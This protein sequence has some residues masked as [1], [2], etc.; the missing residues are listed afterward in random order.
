MAASAEYPEHAAHRRLFS[1]LAIG[2]FTVPNRIVNSTHGTGLDDERELR[3]LQERARGGAGFLG[4]QASQGVRD[5]AVGTGPRRKDP[6]WDERALHP[7]SREGIAHFDDLVIPRLRRRAEI[8]HAEGARC[9]A[10]LYHP[11]AARHWRSVDPVVA[12]STVVDPYESLTP[13]ALRADEVLDLV[14]AFAH[15]IRRIAEAGMDAAELHGAH[16]YLINQFLSPYFNRRTDAWGGAMERRV[17]F[18]VAVIAEA[19][20]LLS[21]SF[22]IGI[23]LGIDGNGVDRGLTVRDMLRACELLAPHVDF[24]SI[25]GGSYAGHG[26]EEEVAYVSPWYQTPGTNVPVAAAVKAIVDVPVIVTGRNIDPALAE[27]ILADGAADLIG[28][29][30]ALIADPE[31]PNKART[32]RSQFIRGCLGLSEC[33]AIGPHRV[34]IT[35]A[36]NASAGREHEPAAQRAGQPKVVAVIGAGPAGMEAARVAAERG[37]R[38]YLADARA[39][40]GG[41]PALLALDD[42][43]RNLRDLAAYFDVQLRH[44]GV[45]L[46]L[47]H[48]VSADELIDFKPDAVIVATGSV[49]RPPDVPGIEGHDVVDCLDVL[50]GKA[51]RDRALVVGGREKH[52]GPPTIAE[53]LADHGK[54]VELISEHLDFFSGI[55]DATRIELIRRLR[56]KGVQIAPLTRLSAIRDGCAV[57]TDVLS[58]QERYLEDVTIVLASS[59]SPDDRLADELR[60]H[61]PIITAVGDALAPRRILHATLDGSRAALSL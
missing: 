46:L 45:E 8:I 53:Y 60:G 17:A 18:V 36:V 37:H 14:S 56:T 39:H 59:R 19:R 50:R 7:L 15:G 54:E 41:T 34:P 33:H 49:L 16:G 11:G 2:D 58:R 30:R 22:P 12:P 29:V 38:V 25:T 23:R 24:I 4:V 61:V 3:Y 52:L 31:L 55:E 40:L 48:T 32:G 28:M 13:H 1:P 35:C 47:G 51:T 57:V 6:R 9:Y 42:N 43:R 5:F 26:G 27:G 10:Q 44:L 21:E 20:S